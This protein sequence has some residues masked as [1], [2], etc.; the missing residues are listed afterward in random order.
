M[1]NKKV[2]SDR[3]DSALDWINK[4]HIKISDIKFQ[5]YVDYTNK[6]LYEI[7]NL[8]SQIN[9]DGYVWSSD[10]PMFFT[11]TFDDISNG[12]VLDKISVYKQRVEI[13]YK[14][15]HVGNH[16]YEVVSDRYHVIYKNDVRDVTDE[17]LGNELM[18]LL[19]S[20]VMVTEC[21]VIGLSYDAVKNY[22]EKL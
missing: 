20:G 10:L 6:N 3:I 14:Y 13:S 8:V 19:E 5:E 9:K 21:G 11:T 1:T 4:H 18:E 15:T 2:I 17:I 7:E 22:I 12:I 16:P